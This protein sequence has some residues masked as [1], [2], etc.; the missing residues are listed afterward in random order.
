MPLR[1]SPSSHLADCAI[2]RTS[3]EGDV[4]LSRSPGERF[5]GAGSIL[6]AEVI[7]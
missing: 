7:A 1:L 3:S 2:R 5:F 4:A 6:A